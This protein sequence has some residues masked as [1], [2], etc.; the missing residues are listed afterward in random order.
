MQVTRAVRAAPG[1]VALLLLLGLLTVLTPGPAS[2]AP[3]A[4]VPAAAPTTDV[5][6]LSSLPGADLTIHL[7]VDG[8]EVRGTEWNERH[9]VDVIVAPPFSLDADPAF[10]AAEEA[11][12]RSTWASLAEDLAPFAVNVTTA[13]PG[14][15]ALTRSSAGDAAYGLRVLL[16]Q[17]TVVDRA[18]RCGGA[19]T[20][21]GF[22]AIGEAGTFGG[23][24]W[25]FSNGG[26]HA[27]LG[28]TAA[29]EVG[30][31]V[32]LLHDGRDGDPYYAGAGAW[33]PLMGAPWSSPVSQWSAGE[34][35]G[36]TTRQDDLALLAARLPLRADEPAGLQVADG[37]TPLAGV[38][39]TRRDVDSWTVVGTGHTATI[40]ATTVAEHPNLDIALTLR[41]PGADPIVVD[42]P[43]ARTSATTAS[44]MDASWRGRIPAG[45]AWTVE[46]DGVGHGDP[47]AP[48]GY[49]DYGSLG[50]YRLDVAGVQAVPGF[51]ATAPTLPELTGGATWTSEPVAVTVADGAGGPAEA[52]LTYTAHGLPAGL[53][54][55]GDG[56]ITGTPQD[57]G[58]FPTTIAV[59]DA[60]GRVASVG[61]T[62]RVRFPAPAVTTSSLPT[63][64]VGAAFRTRLSASGG[65]GTYSWRA[66]GGLPSGI[67]LAR[68][69]TLAGTTRAAGTHAVAVVVASGGLE[70]RR[71]LRLTVVGPLALPP[72]RVLGPARV[73]AAW[74]ESFR[75]SGGVPAYRW[76]WR[77]LPPGVTVALSPSRTA[78]SLSGRPTRRGTWHVVVAVVDGRGARVERTYTVTVS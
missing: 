63:A 15:D 71:T 67:T 59:R 10:S 29:H 65:D 30:H 76:G 51:R 4:D 32:G 45:E 16:T 66:L 54:I 64:D 21:D 75:L 13:D 11:L 50:S 73:G 12:V 19:A 17:D 53:R 33:A 62:L 3:A 23:T 68:D 60:T 8:G 38:V 37:G 1:T 74:S 24:A 36:A 56:R 28:A 44:G 43:S 58:T 52:P 57:G 14:P 39:T 34:Y 5:L 48:G 69:G 77:N 42:P 18:C 78:L 20:P 35:A 26:P 25:V 9:A 2:A 46:V 49:S 40:T 55:T 7:D 22:G 72:A 41:R 47:R 70:A 31:T 6:A 27:G 61:T